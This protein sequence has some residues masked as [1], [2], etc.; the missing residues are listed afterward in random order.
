MLCYFLKCVVISTI[1]TK[2]VTLFITA[3]EAKAMLLALHELVPPQLANRSMWTIPQP[4]TL[5]PFW[6][7]DQETQAYCIW[8]PPRPREPEWLPDQASYGPATSHHFWSLKY[9]PWV[10]HLSAWCR[11]AG[12]MGDPIYIW[13]SY[14][15][16]NSSRSHADHVSPVGVQYSSPWD[17]L[18]DTQRPCAFTQIL[19]TAAKVPSNK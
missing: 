8:L 5:A 7:L 9:L 6:F 1:E 3:Q 15:Q 13:L 2:L 17:S 12:I 16:D 4:C 11:S 10:G 19:Q 14:I 18:V